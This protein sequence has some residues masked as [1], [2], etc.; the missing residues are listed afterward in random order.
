MKK[1]SLLSVLLFINATDRA[2]FC[3][4]ANDGLEKVLFCVPELPEIRFQITEITKVRLYTKI[5]CK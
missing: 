4:S 2:V 3:R 5:D 1:K